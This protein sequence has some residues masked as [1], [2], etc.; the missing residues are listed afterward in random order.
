MFVQVKRRQWKMGLIDDLHR[1]TTEEPI[2][3]PLE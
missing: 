1:L 3:L 2:P